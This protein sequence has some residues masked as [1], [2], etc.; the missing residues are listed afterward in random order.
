MTRV[1]I[2]EAKSFYANIWIGGSYEGAIRACRQYCLD[3]ALCVTVTKTAFVYVGGMEDGACVR[4]IQYPRFPETESDLRKRALDLAWYL[5]TALSQR[6]F[7]IE[8]PDT[9]VYDTLAVAR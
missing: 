2:L 3:N 4:L 7:S 5:R 9:T 8:Y 1:T 6:S